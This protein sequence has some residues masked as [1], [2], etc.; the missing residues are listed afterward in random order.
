M[1]RAIL[2]NP[3][4][5][6]LDEATSAIDQHSER[7]IHETLSAFCTDRTVFI[8]SHV[9]NQTFLDLISR[10]VVLDDGKIVGDG[11]H[12]Q[13]LKNCPQYQNLCQY[14]RLAA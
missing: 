12:E 2:K 8:I 14:D 13:L 9:L 4:I 3:E 7:L 10:V 1:A 5:L 6:I 11:T